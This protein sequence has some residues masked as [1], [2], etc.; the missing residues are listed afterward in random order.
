MD[1]WMDKRLSPCG[2]MVYCG[3]VVE[4]LNFEVWCR[5]AFIR[6]QTEENVLKH[7]GTTWTSN[8]RSIT[9]NKK[10]LFFPQKTFFICLCT[11]EYN[12]VVL[13]FVCTEVIWQ[14]WH[15]LWMC[16]LPIAV[17]YLYNQEIA[18]PLF[19]LKLAMEQLAAN[20]T[21]RCILATVLAIGNFLNGCKVNNIPPSTPLY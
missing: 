10:Y 4:V 6:Q 21:F 9:S 3:G 12:S 16:C 14:F 11:N 7:R 1:G 13:I 20:Q 17:C 15:L 19:H 5:V 18:E 2:I 8:K